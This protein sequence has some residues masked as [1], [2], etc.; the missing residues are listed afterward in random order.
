MSRHLRL[1][2]PTLVVLLIG[3]GFA[4]AARKGGGG[5]GNEVKACVV[6]AGDRKGALR[7]AKKCRKGE[8]SISWAKQGPPGAAGVAGAQGPPGPPGPPGS[9]APGVAAA[10]EPTTLS[11]DAFLDLEGI[12]GDSTRDGHEGEIDVNGFCLTGSTGAF[13]DLTVRAGSGS[14]SAPLLSRLF[15]GAPIS[16]GAFDMRRTI[17]GE[18]GDFQT[19]TFSGL[20]VD[21]YRLLGDVEEIRLSWDAATMSYDGNPAVAL[22]GSGHTPRAA[23]P[24][25]PATLPVVDGFIAWPGLPGESMRDG[26]EGEI[27]MP[28]LCVDARRAYDGA[29]GPSFVAVAGTGTD[30]ATPGLLARAGSG[31]VEA[32]AVEISLR[33]TIAGETSDYIRLQLQGTRVSAIEQ[34]SSEEDATLRATL[35]PSSVSG[36]IVDTPFAG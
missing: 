2:V 24:G 5:G 7:I 35:T 15:S 36:E 32:G 30:L 26:H 18:T 8:R 22:A 13:S 21:G 34:R 27:T 1:I 16:S 23:L 29:A 19:Y 28:G 3:A 6:K 12:P 20:R 25:C 17:A 14:H 11:A 9:T 33:R 31:A 10:C 4:V